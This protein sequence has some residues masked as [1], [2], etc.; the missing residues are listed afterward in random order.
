[1]QEKTRDIQIDILRIIAMFMIILFHCFNNTNIIE[2]G[3]MS[4]VNGII[5]MFLRVVTNVANGIFFIISGYYLIH[6]KFKLKH[7]LTLWGKTILFSTLA[8]AIACFLQLPV[9]I[10]QATFPII[11]GEYWF[12]TAYII[13]Y[14]I[15]PFYNLVL[16]RLTKKQMQYL[17]GILFGVVSVLNIIFHYNV[18]FGNFAVVLLYYAIGAYIQ[19]YYIPK[20]KEYPMAKF[21]IIALVATILYLFVF[22]L[23]ME[24]VENS[25]LKLFVNNLYSDFF[26]L[27]NPFSVLMAFFLFI[28]FYKKAIKK[29][30]IQKFTTWI[31]PSILSVYLIHENTNLNIYWLFLG[32]ND[33]AS[34][35]WCI[36]YILFVTLMVFII[37]L[38]I[39]GIR[40]IS[41]TF[42]KKIPIVNSGTKK[43]N[44]KLEKYNDKITNILYSEESK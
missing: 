23:R 27:K 34:S 7:I 43:L 26:N 10:E 39:D 18:F 3:I 29:P 42:L 32:I 19:K 33:L 40:R 17:L 37:C 31:T 20:E 44:D 11:A 22:A 41:Y 30:I 28:A 36:P 15:Y 14:L 6:K 35:L 24:D 25:Y 13:L 5:A 12:I 16:N 4:D 9:K 21:F 38:I 1:M 8:V 2:R